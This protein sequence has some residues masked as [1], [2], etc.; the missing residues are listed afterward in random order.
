M[1][2]ESLVMNLDNRVLGFASTKVKFMS[3]L[4]TSRLIIT[5]IHGT[6]Y[7]VLFI[8]DRTNLSTASDIQELLPLIAEI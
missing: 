7:F 6:E 2:S 3:F 1:C 4:Y 5:S 8:F